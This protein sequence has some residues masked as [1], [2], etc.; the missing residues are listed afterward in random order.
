MIAQLRL[1]VLLSLD[2]FRRWWR[3]P[4]AKV[5]L[6]L[7]LDRLHEPIRGWDLATRASVGQGTVYVWL[8]QLE[9]AELVWSFAGEGD[10]RR[11][12]RITHHGKMW[13]TARR[14]EIGAWT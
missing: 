13:L 6:L 5:R 8:R 1:L 2:A 11:W 9:E 14:G 3:R 7:V 4:S 10:A 12:Y